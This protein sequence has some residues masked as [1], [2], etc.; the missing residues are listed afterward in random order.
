MSNKRSK[1][2]KKD[3]KSQVYLKSWYI[4]GC[5]IKFDHFQSLSIDF[6][7]FDQIQIRI[8]RFHH[9]KWFGFQEF[10]YKIR[11]KYYSNFIKTDNNFQDNSINS[12]DTPSFLALWTPK[13]VT[14]NFA[15]LQEQWFS[16]FKAHGP[17]EA[18]YRLF[19]PV[20]MNVNTFFLSCHPLI[21]TP[22]WWGPCHIPQPLLILAYSSHRSYSI[23]G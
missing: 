22:L 6:E 21:I 7:L 8:N 14:K 1:S 20:A 12:I 17:V 13:A 2:W 3:R 11:L 9:D 18:H 10:R 16:T 23:V 19:C 4:L 15:D 5:L